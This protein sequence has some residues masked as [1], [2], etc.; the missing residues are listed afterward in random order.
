MYAIIRLFH[1][2]ELDREKI[3]EADER[4]Q[5][6]SVSIAQHEL[7]RLNVMR[8]QDHRRTTTSK[9]AAHQRER[10]KV[11]GMD[12]IDTFAADAIRQGSPLAELDEPRR[13]VAMDQWPPPVFEQ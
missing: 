7:R 5:E 12:E 8:L 3:A 9:Q 2:L 11:I 10:E 6:E 13:L 1:P 4:R